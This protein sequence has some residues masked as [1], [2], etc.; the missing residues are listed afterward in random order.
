MIKK[1]RLN[2]R[3]LRALR[4]DPIYEA[5][6]TDLYL[7]GAIDKQVAETLTGRE[8]ADHLTSPLVDDESANDDTE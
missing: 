4:S 7:I 1:S 5:V 3:R 6:I 2:N 8:I